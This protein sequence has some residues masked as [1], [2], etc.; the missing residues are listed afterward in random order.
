MKKTNL[1][2]FAVLFLFFIYGCASDSKT[3]TTLSSPTSTIV[4][5]TTGD[6]D[7]DDLGNDLTD[8]DSIEDDLGLGDLESLDSELE[9]IDW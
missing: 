3:T 1:L 6:A 8:I 2:F 4:E 9:N 7:V 5:I